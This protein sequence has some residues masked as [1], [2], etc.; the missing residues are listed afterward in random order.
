[1]HEFSFIAFESDIRFN[2]ANLIKTEDFLEL[3]FREGGYVG[4]V[5]EVTIPDLPLALS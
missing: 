4:Q 1:M 3:I 5:L 2:F